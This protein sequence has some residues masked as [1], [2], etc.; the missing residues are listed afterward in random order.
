MVTR[1]LLLFACLLSLPFSTARASTYLVTNTNAS[2]ANSLQAAIDSV[3]THAGPDSIHFNIPGPAPHTIVVSCADPCV[4]NDDDIVLDGYTQPGSAPNTAHVGDPFNGTIAVEIASSSYCTQYPAL[5][6]NGARNIVR[7]IL[8]HNY[9]FA[10]NIVVNGDDAVID[11]CDI[12]AAGVVG[13]DV[14][15]SSGVQIGGTTP[16]SRNLIFDDYY[17]ILVEGENGNPVLNLS[18]QGN[19]IGPRYTQG[20][21][22]IGV[23]VFGYTTGVMIGGHLTAPCTMN[24]AMNMIHDQQGAGI[25]LTG[26]E[27]TGVSILSNIIYSNGGLGIDLGGDGV[28]PNDPGD[29]DTGPNQL[30]NFPRI[31]S[32]Q[33]NSISGVLQ[34]TP[35]RT[36]TIQVFDNHSSA[37]DPSGYGEGKLI[38]GE[39]QAVTDQLG[40]ANFTVSCDSVV[41]GHYY[42][43]TATDDEGNTSEFSECFE[44]TVTAAS[45]HPAVFAL[46]TNVPNPFNPATIIPF[47]MGAAGRVDIVIFDIAGRRVRTL[48]SEYHEA[49][50]G[51]ARWDGRDDHGKPVASGVYFCR[52][53]AGTFSASRKIVLLK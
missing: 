12:E 4:L 31:M 38:Y 8:I 1:H 28:T 42:T 25:A 34:S 22:T 9:H 27:V 26:D 52:M 21:A 7:G 10:Y 39:T 2:G 37:C 3:N 44:S 32:S 15:P 33:E 11:G 46:H 45:D 19:Y 49:G 35:N 17:G 14:R 23:L 6:I 40:Y 18:I 5:T 36:F 53:N 47:E 50:P 16:A 43:A 30:Q 24:G 48:V 29:D 51:T 13:I 41:A 20:P